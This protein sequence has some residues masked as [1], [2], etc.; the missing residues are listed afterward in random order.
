MDTVFRLVLGGGRT[1]TE[2]SS[3]RLKSSPSPGYY[4]A[5]M[6]LQDE[7]IYRSPLISEKG[8]SIFT[9]LSCTLCCL[10]VGGTVGHLYTWARTCSNLCMMRLPSS[11]CCQMISIFS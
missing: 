7:H 6:L 9:E 2:P 5:C 8:H 10:S 3:E 11:G 1:T 4:L